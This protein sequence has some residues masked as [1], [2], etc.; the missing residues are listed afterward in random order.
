[1]KR[2]LVVYHTM[3]GAAQQLAT[4][5][6]SAAREGGDCEAALLTASAAD[7]PHVLGAD[8]YLFVTPENLATMA[9]RM[10]DF[11]DRVYYHVLDRVNGRPYATI[12]AAGTDGEG[13]A[14]QIQRIATGLRLNAIAPPLIIRNGA[15]TTEQILAPKTVREDDLQRARELGLALAAGLASGIF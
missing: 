8:G 2:L 12:I 3:T 7:A 4:A 6:H 14:R 10:K 1:M 15:Q 13:A 11:F 5:A 9:G